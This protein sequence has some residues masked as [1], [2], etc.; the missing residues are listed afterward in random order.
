MDKAWLLMHFL[1]AT[2]ANDLT[3]HIACLHE[4]CP[5]FFSQEKPNYARY[6]SVYLNILLNLPHTHPGAMELL[7]KNGMSVNRSNIP[8]S[9]NA[10][11]ITIEQIY[12]HHASGHGPGIIG[13]SPNLAA[14]HWWGC[15][16]HAR[17]DYLQVS[18]HI[19]YYWYI[20][21]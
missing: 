11:G 9:R 20:T 16:W 5:F 14:Y 3:L 19:M 6:T 13:F 12:N 1:R 21:L 4:L 18:K 15:A 17:A 10:V 7:Q 2:K 8:N